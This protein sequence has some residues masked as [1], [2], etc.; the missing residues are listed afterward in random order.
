MA[1]G[2]HTLGPRSGSLLLRTGR[3]GLGRKAGHDLTIEATGWSADVT[4]AAPESSSVAVTVEVGA[5]EVREGTGGALPLGDSDRADIKKNLRKI[6][7]ADRHP[8]ITFR[9]T[10]VRGTPEEFTVEGDLTIA[11]TTRTAVVR[12]VSADGRIRGGTTVVQTDFGIKPY[13]AFFGAL[14]LADEV[15]IAFDVAL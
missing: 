2:T 5:L 15:E 13:S 1:L 6:L 14:K 10:R 12:G 8:T 9:S 3:A 11:G 7:Q 4:V